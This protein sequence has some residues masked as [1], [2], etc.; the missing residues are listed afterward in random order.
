MSMHIYPILQVAHTQACQPQKQ[1]IA[2]VDARQ[3]KG[4]SRISGSLPDCPYLVLE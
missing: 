2:V 4:Q 3:G 1:K